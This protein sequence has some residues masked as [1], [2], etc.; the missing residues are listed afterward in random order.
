MWIKPAYPNSTMRIGIPPFDSMCAATPPAFIVWLSP[1]MLIDV[2]MSEA[3]DVAGR[4]TH[5]KTIP[6]RTF[7][8]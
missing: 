8:T 6:N 1:A 2:T 3:F 5:D 7:F 4:A